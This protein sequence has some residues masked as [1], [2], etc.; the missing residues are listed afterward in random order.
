MTLVIL[1]AGMGSRFGGLKQVEKIDEEGNF[2]IDYSVYDA[3]R[4][5]FDKIVFI[6][7]EENYEL[8]KST[9]GARVSKIVK[10]EYAFQNNDNIEKYVTIPKSRKKPFG[11]AHAIYCAKEYIDGNFGV[12]SADDFYGKDAFVKLYESLNNN[13]ISLIGYKLKNT[14]SVNGSVKR[15]I[16][17]SKDG[18]V[19]ENNDFVIENVDNKIIGKEIIG[20]REIELSE[21]QEVAM[22]MYGLSKKVI[23][24]I[25]HDIKKFLSDNK[26]NIDS[27]EYLLPNVLTEMIKKDIIKMRLIPTEE[28]WMGITYK[29][30]LQSL[31]DYIKDLKKSGV[32][33]DKLY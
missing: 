33:P 8:F 32:Y 5:G 22:L 26:D 17:F 10:V 18:Y 7:N 28:K 4:A 1:A 20:N 30:D 29:E 19:T 31:K 6:I 16:C 12:I 25:E 23:D 3:V 27:I 24:Y 11:T 15:G 14:M 13:I 9:I 2:I 21:N